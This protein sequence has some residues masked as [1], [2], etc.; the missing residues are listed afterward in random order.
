[1]SI[2]ERMEENRAQLQEA[3]RIDDEDK[4]K[5][6]ILACMVDRRTIQADCKHVEEDWDSPDGN[7]TIT[8]CAICAKEITGLWG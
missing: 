4:R 7:V 2:S 6:A 5:E 3:R 1:M 8:Y